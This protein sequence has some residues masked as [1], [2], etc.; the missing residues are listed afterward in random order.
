[1]LFRSRPAALAFL[2]A[3][4]WFGCF[5]LFARALEWFHTIGD[6]GP[7]LTER[8]LVLL[9]VTFF[10]ILLLSNTIT[11][12]TTFFLADDVNLLLAA[13]IEPRGAAGEFDPVS[14]RYTLHAPTQGSKGIQSSIASTGIVGDARALRV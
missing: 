5:A 11:A 6:F 3:L 14:G 7:L 4:F 2:T 13:P 12:L 9:F 10:T 8:L 1:M